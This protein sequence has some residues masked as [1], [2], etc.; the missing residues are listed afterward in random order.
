MI[1]TKLKF[2]KIFAIAIAATSTVIAFQNCGGFQTSNSAAE[3]VSRLRSCDEDFSRCVCTPSSQ[4]SCVTETGMGRQACNATGLGFAA[5]E[6]YSCQAGFTFTNGV[7]KSDVCAA[8]DAK[9]C[10]LEHG[11]GSRTCAVPASGGAPVYGAC[12]ASSCDAGYVLGLGRCVSATCSPG[13]VFSCAV[14]N[15]TGSRTC[16]TNSTWGSC[17]VSR[18]DAN[19]SLQNGVCVLKSCTAGTQQSCSENHGRGTQTCL[20]SGAAFGA[21]QL[22]VCDSGYSLL[23]GACVPQ[24]CVPGAQMNCMENNGIGQKTCST[25]GLSFGSCRFTSCDSGYTLSKGACVSL[26]PGAPAAGGAKGGDQ[27]VIVSQDAIVNGDYSYVGGPA[28]YNASIAGASMCGAL[29]L[30][31]STGNVFYPQ[32]STC[33]VTSANSNS[34]LDVRAKL[35]INGKLRVTGILLV[36]KDATVTVR[37]QISLGSNGTPGV[38]WVEPGGKVIIEPD[39]GGRSSL[40]SEPTD[41]GLIINNGGDVE[42]K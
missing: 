13:E 36:S 17:V 31:S 20:T 24:S 12:V 15:G 32:M 8:G 14:P 38:I 9:A 35:T 30:M 21:C 22:S 19:S 3:V 39:A 28:T 7:C 29:K 23:S 11:F 5:C 6:P 33:N 25:N 37:G 2:L 41:L 1:L 42:L 4:I 10:A 34:Y 16:T 27:I 40:A 18:C 26:S